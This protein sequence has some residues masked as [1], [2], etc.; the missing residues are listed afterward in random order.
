MKKRCTAIV[1][2][3]GGGRRMNSTVAKQFMLLGDKPL[4]WYSLRAAEQSEIIDDCILVTGKEAIPYV[5]KEIVEKY[6][7]GKVDTIVPG[8]RERWESVANAVAAL[9]SL[10]RPTPNRDGY[11]F[12]HDGAR[13]FLT[14]DILSRTYETVQKYH[15]CV[16]AMPSKDTVKLADEKGIAASTPDRRFVWSVQTPQV[17]DTELIVKAYG[18]L[19]EKADT[20]GFEAVTVTDDASVAELFTD[21]PVKLTE[22]SYE[23][24]KITTPEDMKIA[25]MFLKKS[26]DRQTSFC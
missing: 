7:F 10:S 9:G 4:L 26:V 12:I 16:A 1:L 6:G 8:G 25:E 20:E 3:A 11:V 2:A 19:R 17:F 15:A 23:N 13:P 18:A 21:C 5:K 24:I 14:E 22:G